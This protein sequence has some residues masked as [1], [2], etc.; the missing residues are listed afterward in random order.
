MLKLFV[1]ALAS[2]AAVSEGFLLPRPAVTSAPT[3]GRGA[4]LRTVLPFVDSFITL[5]HGTSLA[6]AFDIAIDGREFVQHAAESFARSWVTRLVLGAIGSAIAGAVVNAAKDAWFS[7]KARATSGN[8]DFN[9][10]YL[11]VFIDVIGD[12][13]YLLP[14]VGEGEDL[15]WAPIS[16]L[17]VGKIFNSSALGTLDFAKE[18]L[19]F[20]DVLPVATLGWVLQNLYPEA[21]L[22]K[23]LGL[24]LPTAAG[25][26]PAA[27]EARDDARALDAEVTEDNRDLKQLR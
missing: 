13:S 24:A 21:G 19:P 15:L 17:V 9:L 12:T 6:V 26:K 22:T 2:F 11:C 1:A 18:I 14:G 7:G 5:D 23:A 20:S 27:A 16:A 3:A 8:V 25:G 4:V 10:L